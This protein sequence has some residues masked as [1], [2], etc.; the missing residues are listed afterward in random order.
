MGNATVHEIKK[1]TSAVLLNALDIIN[2]TLKTIY[3]MPRMESKLEVKLPKKRLP[4]T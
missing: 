1:P 4:Q 2:H 3:Y